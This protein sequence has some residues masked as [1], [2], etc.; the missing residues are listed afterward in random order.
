V[1]STVDRMC[2]EISVD[3]RI[4]SSTQVDGLARRDLSQ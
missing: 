4:V 1:R 2:S 3:P